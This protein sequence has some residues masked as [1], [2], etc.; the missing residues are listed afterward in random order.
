MNT[1]E[2][3]DI[4]DQIEQYVAGKLEGQALV[5][6]EQRL[7]ADPQLAQ[8]V[9]LENALQQAVRLA[10][11]VTQFRE[12]LK[13]ADA[14]LIG[15]QR[16]KTFRISRLSAIAATALLLLA[17]W[18]FFNRPEPVS[19]ADLFAAHFH[20]HEAFSK[21]NRGGDNKID[22]SAFKQR[23]DAAVADLNAGQ[24]EAAIQKF[25]QLQTMPEARAYSDDLFYAKGLACLQAG[26]PQ[27]AIN[28]FEAIQTSFPS[29]KPWYLAL[30]YYLAG[31]DA[32]A[33]TAFEQIAQSASPY[34][35]E[36]QEMLESL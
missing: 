4:Q 16:S 5:D 23:W 7:S 18:W 21:V 28:S 34:K 6:F 14:Q 27:E 1:P 35:K 11:Q 31:N 10:P 17:A 29:E 2:M 8:R 24:Y 30:S 32:A 12:Q 25:D 13:A 36:A 20:P 19:R 26:K 33:R 22:T 15:T 9:R 3:D